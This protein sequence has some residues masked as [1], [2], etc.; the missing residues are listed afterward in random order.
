[1]ASAPLGGH[2]FVPAGSASA[3]LHSKSSS[4]VSSVQLQASKRSNDEVG[5]QIV[6]GATAFIT[7]LVF[8][9]RVAFADSSVLINNDNFY[10]NNGKFKVI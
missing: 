2:S 3:T 1:M 7:G 4:S 5:K 6:G 8:A 9:T 10:V